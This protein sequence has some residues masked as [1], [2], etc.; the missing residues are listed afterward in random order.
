M[1]DVLETLERWRG[2][3]LPIAV[4]TVVGVEQ[5]APRD[6]G[7]MMAVN[8]RGDVAGSV[9]GGCVESAVYDEAQDAI[10]T[11]RPRLVT[12]GI[13]D[14]DAISVGLTCGGTIHVFVERLDW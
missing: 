4:A 8:A 14:E 10:A 2:E 11:G 1:K 6:P 3:G 7:A 9:S 12:Y 5:S 13:S